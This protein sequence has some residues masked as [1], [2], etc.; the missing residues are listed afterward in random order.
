MH[1]AEHT[2]DQGMAIGDNIK[3]ARENKGLTR[4]QAAELCGM[5]ASTWTKYERG[6]VQ[7]TASPIRAMAKGL[8]VS[9][10]ELLLDA[11]ERSIPADL[12]ALF[13]EISRLPE[14]DQGEIRRALKGHIMVLHQMHMG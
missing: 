6:E 9:T 10:D 4:E 13:R 7:P 2:S 3:K 14:A 11:D 1:T 12:I 5:S 8:Q